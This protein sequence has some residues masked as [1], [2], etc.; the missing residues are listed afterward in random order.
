[1]AHPGGRPRK[2]KNARQLQSAIDAY[3][4]SNPDHPT[5]TGL[6]L[7]LGFCDR[8]SFHDYE[9]HAKYSF[10]IKRARAEVEK[11]YEQ[12]LIELKNPGGA[13]F[14]LKNFNWS[15]KQ[16]IDHT[17][18]GEKINSSPTFNFNGIEPDELRRLR[19]TLQ[20]AKS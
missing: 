19:D 11:F 2:F 10:T 14:A 4:A 18:R 7:S 6:A 3:F 8:Q 1:M 20:R 16:E 15:D 17:T 5:M 13:I 12:K 9:K